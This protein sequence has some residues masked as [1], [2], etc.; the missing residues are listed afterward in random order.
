MLYCLDM[1]ALRILNAS[2]VLELD[3]GVPAWEMVQRTRCGLLLPDSCSSTKH[4]LPLARWLESTC[5]TNLFT[6]FNEQIARK[7]ERL[8]IFQ[9]LVCFPVEVSIAAEASIA[10][11]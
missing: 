2:T 1:K 7:Q 4:I 11:P 9:V 8:K 6:S 5:Q 10:F 3:F